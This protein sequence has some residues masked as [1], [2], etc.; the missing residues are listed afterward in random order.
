MRFAL[1]DV[2][3]RRVERTFCAIIPRY[4]FLNPFEKFLLQV[5]HQAAAGKE[6]SQPD[7][8]SVADYFLVAPRRRPRPATVFLGPLRVRALVRV[9]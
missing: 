2:E 1:R 5:L 9:R 4:K 8:R 3:V 6:G 7:F